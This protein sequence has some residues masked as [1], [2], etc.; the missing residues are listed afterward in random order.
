MS[1]S[2]HGFD[3]ADVDRLIRNRPTHSCVTSALVEAGITVRALLAENANCDENE[4][5]LWTCSSRA[6]PPRTKSNSTV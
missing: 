6:G 1:Y 4:E 3:P 5:S 2:H